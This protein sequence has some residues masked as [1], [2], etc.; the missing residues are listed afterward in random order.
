MDSDRVNGDALVA[1]LED[2]Y[3]KLLDIKLTNVNQLYKHANLTV[4]DT[5][6]MSVY[7]SPKSHFRM[8]A[9][10][11]IWRDNKNDNTPDGFYYVSVTFSL[12]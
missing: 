11:N 9:N 2:D 6:K 4:P 7:K 12:Y 3:D 1:C 5:V 10:F 8:R